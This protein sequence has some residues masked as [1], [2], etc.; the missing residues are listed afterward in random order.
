MAHLSPKT[1]SFVP[2]LF[3][4]PA[5]FTWQMAILL[6]SHLFI[7]FISSYI[8]WNI[9]ELNLMWW[10][11]LSELRVSH[12]FISSYTRWISAVRSA[13]GTVHLLHGR[14]KPYFAASLCRYKPH[15]TTRYYIYSICN[16]RACLGLTMY[17]ANFFIWKCTYFLSHS[18]WE[19][20]GILW[21]FLE[22][23]LNYNCWSLKKCRLYSPLETFCIVGVLIERILRYA[24]SHV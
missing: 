6:L 10:L 20:Q 2:F 15:V 13:Y 19:E 8:W 23:E 21:L 4:N 1:L 9:I 17:L 11:V 5:L 24:L 14:K 12:L 7:F 22:W 18:E 3:T 16:K